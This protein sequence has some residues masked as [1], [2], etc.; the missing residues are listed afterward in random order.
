MSVLKKIFGKL[1]PDSGQTETDSSSDMASNS[2]DSLSSSHLSVVE[3]NMMDGS[4]SASA[5]RAPRVALT[6]LHRIVFM[7]MEDK[8][9]HGGAKVANIST[10]GMAILRGVT[11][12]METGD[13]LDLNW[14]LDGTCKGIVVID[15]EVFDVV[16]HVRHLSPIIAGCEFQET[17]NMVLKRA[18]EAYLR[19]EILALTL[20]KVNEAYIKPDPRGKSYWFTDGRQNELFVVVDNEGVLSYHMSF[21]GHYVEGGRDQSPRV[22]G[23]NDQGVTPFGQ[24]GATLIEVSRKPSGNILNLALTFVRNVNQLPQKIREDIARN[25]YRTQDSNE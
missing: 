11:G 2:P 20:R 1:R 17:E 22:G 12:K 7:P 25:L 3:S 23:L 24:K 13:H 21:L 8:L 16:L 10:T 18:I 15:K 6:P 5:R 19:V 4:A 14:V 9:P